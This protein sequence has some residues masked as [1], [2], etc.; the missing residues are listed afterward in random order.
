MEITKVNEH[1]TMVYIPNPSPQLLAFIKERQEVK[2]I[3]MEEI[4]QQYLAE[5]EH[6]PRN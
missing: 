1:T 5:L 6:K 2:R 3:R 4:R